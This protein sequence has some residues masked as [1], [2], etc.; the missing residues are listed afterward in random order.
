MPSVTPAARSQPS[1]P[2]S[3]RATKRMRKTKVE[4]LYDSLN[5]ADQPPA[6]S[7]EVSIT[8]D[9]SL[10][11]NQSVLDTFLYWCHER[12]RIHL[13]R[14]QGL[15]QSQWTDDPV[16]KLHKFANVF[17][18]LDRG[19]QFVLNDVIAKGDQSLEECCFRVILFRSF[20]RVSTY[21]LIAEALGGPPSYATFT[22]ERY[23][24][25][26]LPHV[27]AGKPIYGS[28][29]FIPAPREFKYEYPFQSTLRLISLMMRTEL[30]K[31]LAELKHMRDAHSVVCVY[32][33]IGAFLGMQLL[34]DLNLTP[35]IDVSEDEYAACGPGSR[36]CLVSMFGNFVQGFELQAMQWIYREQHTH[37]RRLGIN[38]PP[39]LCDARPAGINMVDVEHALC[40]VHKYMRE[41]DR[42]T[43]PGTATRGRKSKRGA[44]AGMARA[45][46]VAAGAASGSRSPSQSQALAADG[47]DGLSFDKI[48]SEASM[49]ADGADPVKEEAEELE[50]TS[51]YYSIYDGDLTYTLPQKWLA[52]RPEKEYER[53]PPE[54][55]GGE[56]YEVS[57]IVTITQAS[58]KCL[59][60][61]K[62]FGPEDD[63]WEDFDELY[64]GAARES[65]EA[66]LA[67]PQ[68][69]A[70]EI[71][72][73]QKEAEE[74]K[75]R[76]RTADLKE[77]AVIDV[78]ART[79]GRPMRAAA[80]VRLATAAAA[81]TVTGGGLPLA[82]WFAS[83]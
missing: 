24:N 4:E 60:R 45:K 59:V 78:D 37:W 70:D 46:I 13:R 68:R 11:L 74:A 64:N 39:K 51:N 56:I 21:Q 41:R 65:V 77:L 28:S 16:F 27:G 49:P 15:P 71:T 79:S 66:Y 58:K 47:T 63:T 62:G 29:Y 40:E 12:H 9:L 8:P 53:P 17:R 7:N 20:A 6:L 33:A 32:P 43:R 83:A 2:D 81:A 5:D 80:P 26:L 61:W 1:P 35:H 25:I 36:S 30:P 10:P 57:H 22:P 48:K 76:L 52:P 14:R 54:D 44:R 73:L 82:S 42:K 67:W 69:V 55:D 3:P 23:E 34:L 31:K 38:D 72:K 50:D 75:E 19:T 18:V